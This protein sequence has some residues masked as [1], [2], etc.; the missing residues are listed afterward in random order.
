MFQNGKHS[1]YPQQRICAIALNSSIFKEKDFRFSVKT[2]RVLHFAPK[3]WGNRL[4]G[5][6][7]NQCQKIT[8]HSQK[9]QKAQ[10]KIWQWGTTVG[11]EGRG[12]RPETDALHLMDV[13]VMDWKN[14]EYLPHVDPLSAT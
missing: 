6:R 12:F 2:S 3:H 8:E 10:T 14:K 7:V 1:T 11:S 4:S 9:V 13:A 5:C